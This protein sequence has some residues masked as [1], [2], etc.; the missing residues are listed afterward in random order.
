MEKPRPSCAV[1]MPTSAAGDLEDLLPADEL[2]LEDTVPDEQAAPDE[3]DEE[4]DEEPDELPAVPA[5]G[6][7]QTPPKKPRVST[8]DLQTLRAAKKMAD[9]PASVRPRLQMRLRRDL[10]KLPSW[11]VARHAEAKSRAG[12]QALTFLLA[13]ADGSIPDK[14][15]IVEQSVSLET[16]H[17]ETDSW[18]WMNWHECMLHF[19]GFNHKEQ[20]KYVDLLWRAATSAGRSRPH[21]MGHGLKA[22]HRV[23]V[24]PHERW[25]SKRQRKTEV[26]TA[27][28]L[29][30][31]TE[32]QQ[33]LEAMLG[34]SF[35][36]D[37]GAAA[38]GLPASAAAPLQLQELPPAD[39]APSAQEDAPNRA[40][41]L[42][43]L[44]KLMARLKTTRAVQG[45]DP[46]WG[47]GVKNMLD[48][49]LKDLVKLQDELETV[50]VIQP[51]RLREGKTLLTRGVQAL[52]K[53][54]KVVA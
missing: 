4:M 5:A 25:A 47:A 7:F 46:I 33:M 27:G 6:L 39:T 24:G 16:A 20:R 37:A 19:G 30:S 23:W 18:A 38:S 42:A 31:G 21:P 40:A 14:D 29:G 3:D 36:R 8:G 35:E 12:V 34:P 26:G 43:E 51:E 13:W 15:A 1:A 32:M 44:M 50:A 10:S 11:A 9:L 2:D 52:Q 17:E 48:P 54:S 28:T 53:L 22:Q 45:N 49:V 41:V